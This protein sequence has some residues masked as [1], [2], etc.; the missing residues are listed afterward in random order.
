MQAR[1][2][3]LGV[4]G[5]CMLEFRQHE[6]TYTLG[7]GGDVF[8]TAVYASRIGLDVTFISAIGDD[9]YSQYLMNAWKNEGLATE[10]VRIIPGL[11]PSLYIINTDELGERT[12]HYWREASPFKQ[13]LAA[14]SYLGSLPS[15]LTSCQCIYF[16]GITLGLLSNDDRA[17]LLDLLTSY[18]ETGGIVAFDSNYRPRLWNSIKE[19]Q[20]WIN[21]AY[22]ISNIA[23]P[24]F[25]DEALLRADKSHDSLIERI[26]SFGVKEIIL[27][28][29]KKGAIV[30]IEGNTQSIA[31]VS[32]EST[33]IVD[34]TAAGDSF[35]GA[36]LA[37]RLKGHDAIV[38][39][40]LGCRV[41]AKIIQHRGAIISSDVSLEA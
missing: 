5:E 37:T 26:Q 2:I 29:G 32:L 14:G 6:D 41:A 18:Q 16:S 21:R 23:F 13:L 10:S 8:N 20:V 17:L 27:K 28:D 11:T 25:D 40:E 1:S 19:A 24:S 4:I 15:T 36:Y 3:P 39:A 31:A 22:S 38:S 9:H 7:Y 35:N 33:A 34:T 12:F 30:S